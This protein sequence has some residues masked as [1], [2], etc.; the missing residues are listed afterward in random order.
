LSEVVYKYYGDGMQLYSKKRIIV[1][2]AGGGFAWESQALIKALGKDYEYHFVTTSDSLGKIEVLN[3]P[4]GKIHVITKPTTM[5]VRSVWIRAINTLKGFW[6][7]YKVVK[8][9]NPFAIIC[10]GTSLSVPL[11]FWGKLFKKKTIFIESIT[12]VSK[13]SVTGRIISLLRLSN[14]FYVQWPEAINLYK[15]SI[16]KG[17]IL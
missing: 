3:L 11:C 10:L 17:T 5:N 16:Y 15:R 13:P 1:T 6:N 9:T 14:R 12:R 4:K 7:A 2:V 8:K